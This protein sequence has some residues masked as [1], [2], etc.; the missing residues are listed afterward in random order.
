ML[1][2]LTTF[3]IQ[4]NE[5]I[6][7]NT[8]GTVYFGIQ[9]NINNMSIN[10]VDIKYNNFSNPNSSFELYNNIPTVHPIFT[11]TAI[12]GAAPAHSI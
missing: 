3:H 5:F 12:T 8:T 11:Q 1:S 9:F 4:D 10:F 6:N 7:N 2:A